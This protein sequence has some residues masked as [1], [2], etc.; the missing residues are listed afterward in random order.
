MSFAFTPGLWFFIL[1]AIVL[2]GL[3]GVA[4]QFRTISTGR[5]FL[6]LITCAL[7]W[8]VGFFFETMAGSLEMKILMA[9]IAFAG[10][11][12]IPNVW[13]Y[14][15]LSF[16]GKRLP[17]RAWILLAIVPA[18]TN[19][20]IWTNPLHR[21][22]RGAPYI[23]SISAPF[24]V[25]VNDYQFWFYFVHAP[26]GYLYILAAILVMTHG[27]RKMQAIYRRQAFLL[28]AALLLPVI[29]DILY[30]LGYSPIKYYNIT[31]AVFSVS[32]AIIAWNLFRFKFL[33]LRP[34][35]RDMI[36]DNLQDGIIVL[37]RKNR[38]VDFN[39]A[40]KQITELTVEAIGK[41]PPEL[42]TRLL[43][44]IDHLIAEG[45]TWMEIEVGETPT[46]YYELRFSNIQD[47]TG[48]LIG[49]IVTLHNNTERAALFRKVE[50][51]ATHDN[52]TGL[53]NRQH[54]FDLAEHELQKFPPQMGYSISVVMFDL[55]RFKQI[56]DRHG[57][58][59]GDKA[60]AIVAK[61]CQ[62]LLRPTD[63]F[64]RIG[65][66]EFAV[67][68]VNADAKSACEAAERLRKGIKKIKFTVG[69]NKIIL[70]GSFGIHSAFQQGETI[71]AILKRADKAMYRAKQAGGNCIAEY[72][73]A[74]M[75]KQPHEKKP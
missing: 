7:I 11:I 25:L 49:R 72:Q 17:A 31:P 55:D 36:V 46:H 35:A 51:A 19:L 18:I 22:F 9:N 33:D 45:R 21:W 57:H 71:N 75:D 39:H 48:A 5:A 10:V 63:I 30:V 4:W 47:P 8:V 42:K 53:L 67:L 14:L 1:A 16:R 26:S 58:E 73:N 13:L 52:L 50:Y 62:K 40:A 43:G 37:D 44:T 59:A 70:T 64:G 74:E 65:G 12:F 2:A 3:M 56:N 66:D 27:L 28:I 41:S 54:F 38:I 32:A 23:D 29:T 24:P 15:A 61:N 34:M 20:L 68:L 60:L 6:L 69:Q